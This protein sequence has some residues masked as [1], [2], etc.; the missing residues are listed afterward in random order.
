[1]KR[2][3][4]LT[5]LHLP[6]WPL[7]LVALLMLCALLLTRSLAQS[8][9]LRPVLAPALF[10][11]SLVID[12]GHGGADPGMVGDD[13][14]EAEINLAVAQALA[15]YCRSAGAAVTLTREGEEALAG[16]K[17]ED[18]QARVE[19]TAQAQADVFLSLHCN[20]YVSSPSQHGA[21]IFYRSGNDEAQLLAQIMQSSLQAELANTERTALTHPDSYLLKNIQGPAVIVEM[22]FLSNKEE[23]AL[24]GTELYQWQMAWALYC[25]LVEYLT[26][27]AEQ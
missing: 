16:G 17:R 22:G 20:S 25:G 13:S 2:H 24:L 9:W 4:R 3:T 14:R 26:L 1:M 27:A 12:P 15:E 18:M 23:E 11:A 10:G 19:L 6:H 5:V 7:F 8:A 21:Q